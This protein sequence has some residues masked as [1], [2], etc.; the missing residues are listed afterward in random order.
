MR[1]WG[2]EYEGK[3]IVG[4]G[5]PPSE[6]VGMKVVRNRIVRADFV[7]VEGDR[8]GRQARTEK[9]ESGFSCVKQ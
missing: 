7:G 3:W 2:L 9:R 8:V 4:R 6:R 1:S 5:R